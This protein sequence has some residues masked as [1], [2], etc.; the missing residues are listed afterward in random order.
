MSS[1]TPARLLH[2]IH[3]RYGLK[4][5]Y[6]LLFI[7]NLIFF[8]N[9]L[10]FQPLYYQP[11]FDVHYYTSVADS[12]M[13]GI[14]FYDIRKE[15]PSSVTTPQNGIVFVH[16]LL[17]KIRIVKQEARL[18]FIM[19]LNYLAFIGSSFLIYRI[20]T[21]FK[22][23][24]LITFLTVSI[25]MFSNHIFRLLLIPINDGI[26]FFLAMLLIYLIIL[27]YLGNQLKNIVLIVLLSIVITHFRN[28]G[29]LILLCAAISYLTQRD[30]K[31]SFF[32]CAMMGLSYLSIHLFYIFF[33]KEVAGIEQTAK[34][35]LIH[36][37]NYNLSL[38]GILKPFTRTLPVLFL[39]F[40][41][42]KY[43]FIVKYSFPVF[44]ISY[45]IF[46]L[47]WVDDLRKK[48]I[49][50]IFLG[51]YVILNIFLLYL[52]SFTPRYVLTIFPFVFLL[53]SLR[54]QKFKLLRNVLIVYSIFFLSLS[55]FKLFFFDTIYNQNLLVT[56]NVQT[57]IPREYI[58][59]SKDAGHSYFFFNKRTGDNYDN[60]LSIKNVL[61]FGD[62]AFINDEVS[63]IASKYMIQE[64]VSLSG[65]WIENRYKEEYKLVRIK[66]KGLRDKIM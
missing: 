46:T 3:D 16:L 27:N 60:V 31:K 45:I 32:Y 10:Y 11:S 22:I 39:G 34:E 66:I 65:A 38:H 58:L 43:S 12:I 19:S 4:T 57:Q 28:Q 40:G 51:L 23:R 29:S 33:V 2:L 25:L 36:S 18:A 50:R 26:F 1:K 47:W 44:F 53:I 62:S 20:F 42:D 49:E 8:I 56:K 37:Y 41:D 30:Y 55:C 21:L 59:I 9:Y 14:G 63:K 7:I 52:S 54:F 17:M 15:V 35:L 5:E 64:S 24:A 6:L 48:Q 13:G 61:I